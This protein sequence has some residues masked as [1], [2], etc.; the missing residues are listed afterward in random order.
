MKAAALWPKNEGIVVV[1]QQ[2]PLPPPV[3]VDL[4]FIIAHAS[5]RGLS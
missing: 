3:L 1:P 2:Y 5:R 4:N